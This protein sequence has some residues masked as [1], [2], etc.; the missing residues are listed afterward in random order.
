[1]KL[2]NHIYNFLVV[3]PSGTGKTTFLS[4]YAS[5][6]HSKFKNE[7]YWLTFPSIKSYLDNLLP[8]WIHS[9]TNLL[10]DRFAGTNT[11]PKRTFVLGDEINRLISKYDHAKSEG[12]T[13][14]DLVSIHR[15]KA[16]DLLVSDQVFDFLKGVRS[17]SHW[18]IF[19]GL[20]DTLYYA[21]KDNLSPKLMFWVDRFQNELLELG[22]K[23]R[24][25]IP[26]GEGKV[27]VT[28]GANSFVL[29]FERPK[30][31]TDELSTVWKMVSPQDLRRENEES[32]DLSMGYDFSSDYHK[33]L[34]L[35]Y[36]LADKLFSGKI[37]KE[38]LAAAYITA[39][40]AVTD[41]PKKLP[42][43]GRG[44]PEMVTT[45]HNINCNW[46]DNPTDY[47]SILNKLLET[48]KSQVAIDE[49]L[50]KL[51]NKVIKQIGG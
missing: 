14:V 3:G 34:M 30:W 38:K 33:S 17:R 19:T 8:K 37:T 50:V 49:N 6:H 11:N 35:A 4:S 15:H 24:E 29:D 39:T 26:S 7:G 5:N 25:T 36:H 10:D 28:N 48:K 41:E 31:Y 18:I 22:D 21:L 42:D 16:F 44:G 1:L 46:C 12:K 20:N 13:F 45:L 9:T 43:S 47:K 40:I 51:E 27:V 23:N 2:L 32:E